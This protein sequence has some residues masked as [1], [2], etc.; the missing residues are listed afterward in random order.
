MQLI[1]HIIVISAVTIGAHLAAMELIWTFVKDPD[2]LYSELSGK[3]QKALKPLLY[4]PTCMAS[5]WGTSLH[6]LLGGSVTYWIPTVFAV[7]FVNTL[8]NKW[9]N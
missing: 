5:V 6:F 4:C 1:T 7:A 2:Q 8:F 9:V 3:V